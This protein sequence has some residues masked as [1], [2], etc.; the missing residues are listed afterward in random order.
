MINVHAILIAAGESRRMG[1]PKQLLPWGSK[2]LIEHQIEILQ[3]AQLSV[4]V[5]LGANYEL[6]EDVISR[7]AVQIYQ[8]KQWQMGMGSSIACRTK[9]IEAHDNLYDGILI[10]LVDQPLISSAHFQTM[11]KSFEPGRNQIIVSQSDNG[12]PGPPVLFDVA[13]LDELTELQGA[14]GAKPII[15]KHKDKVI[16]T[17]CQSNL[18]D[19]DTPEAYQR[20]LQMANL[21]S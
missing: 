6:I 9:R 20:L 8:N 2:T 7:F 14:E 12:I 4:S 5:I 16:L 10:A 1:T 15:K 13:Y 17:P 18:E 3:N 11:I 19:M 21:Q